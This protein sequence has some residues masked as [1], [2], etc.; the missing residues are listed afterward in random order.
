PCV[1][2][3]RAAH[4]RSGDGRTNQGERGKWEERSEA[5]R[6]ASSRGNSIFNFPHLSITDSILQ[7]GRTFSQKVPRCTE[8]ANGELKN[9][10]W[11]MEN[12][13]S[14]SHATTGDDL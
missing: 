8:M 2:E 12:G 3:V 1:A 13:K 9:E 5:R 6:V 11:K 14:N 4:F 7:A 10:K